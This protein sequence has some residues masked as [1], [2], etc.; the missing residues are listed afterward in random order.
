MKKWMRIAGI[1][2]LLTG[3]MT[4][5]CWAAEY[6]ACADQMQRMGLFRGTEQGG[7]L[8]R[9]PTRAEAAVMLVRLL[10]AEDEASALDYKAPFVDLKGWEQPYVQY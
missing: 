8:D 6:T 5:S 10:G 9:V 3:M 4:V 2:V 7:E 1:G